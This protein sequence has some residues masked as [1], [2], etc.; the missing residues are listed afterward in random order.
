VLR[1]EVP[2][3]IIGDRRAWDGVIVGGEEPVGLEAETRILDAQAVERRIALKQRDGG[4]R[5]VVLLV[6][7]SAANRRAVD[8]ASRLL[9]ERFPLDSRSVLGALGAGRIPPASG[10]AFLRPWQ[11]RSG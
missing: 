5:R 9:T 2:L 11:R 3:P 8:S 1:T 7:D 10:I 6:L 4:I